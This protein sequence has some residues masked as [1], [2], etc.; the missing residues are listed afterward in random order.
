MTDIVIH[1]VS[2][3]A[4]HIYDLAGVR[5]AADELILFHKDPDT[6]EIIKEYI[7]YASI[8]SYSVTHHVSIERRVS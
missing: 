8:A 5:A 6:G 7:R 2:G 4:D 1:Y 3:K